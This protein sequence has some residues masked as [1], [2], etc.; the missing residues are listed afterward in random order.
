M[1]GLEPR[2][3]TVYAAALHPTSPP[4]DFD[5]AYSC[6]LF[7]LSI[8]TKLRATDRGDLNPSLP[9]IHFNFYLDSS[10]IKWN[11]PSTPRRSLCWHFRGFL[12]VAIASLVQSFD[13]WNFTWI[14]PMLINRDCIHCY[15]Q[16]TTDWESK[17]RLNK[18]I[19]NFKA[20]TIL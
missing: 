18:C 2:K 16:E 6:P 1:G 17:V 9:G 3:P 20:E 5:A 19:A 14:H 12:N 4:R 11:F 13:S 7:Q 15:K 10:S 8:G